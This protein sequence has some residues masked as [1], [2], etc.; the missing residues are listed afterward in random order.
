MIPWNPDATAQDHLAAAREGLPCEDC[1]GP[2]WFFGG[3]EDPLGACATCNDDEGKPKPQPLLV[4]RLSKPPE[5]WRSSPFASGREVRS[6][7]RGTAEGWSV[8]YFCDQCG[9]E[10]VLGGSLPGWWACR[11]LAAAETAAGVVVLK[12]PQ[13][14]RVSDRA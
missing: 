12:F 11:C 10:A 14:V 6:R 7:R 2:G 3:V 9:G 5:P 8:V 13:P 4:P 1:G